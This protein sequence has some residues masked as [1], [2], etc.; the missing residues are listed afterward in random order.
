MWRGYLFL[1]SRSSQAVTFRNNDDP[2]S[3]R[4]SGVSPILCS[5]VD[6]ADTCNSIGCKYL[7]RM[8][9]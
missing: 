5:Y 7:R 4:K 8:V 1:L 3:R 9:G 6:H 2:P